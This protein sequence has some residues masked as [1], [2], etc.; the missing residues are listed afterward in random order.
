MKKYKARVMQNL[1][2]SSRGALVGGLLAGLMITLA[3]LA[4]A[5]TIGI[6]D[7]RLID[8]TELGDGPQNIAASIVGTD[9]LI[10]AAGFDLVTP[11]CTGAGSFACA[12]SG[13][14][15]LVV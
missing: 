2:R 11:G 5:G 15:E 1:G 8:G 4:S 3:P 7:G 13:F 12:L 6:L 10:T 9:L 14:N